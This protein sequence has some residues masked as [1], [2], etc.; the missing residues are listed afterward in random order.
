MDLKIKIKNKTAHISYLISL[1]Y[2]FII[3]LSIAFMNILI[4]GFCIL[5]ILFLFEDG[6]LKH[7][8]YEINNRQK[9]FIAVGFLIFVFYLL[10]I[11]KSNDKLK[12]LE[13]AGRI[14]SFV[15]F[16]F[17]YLFYKEEIQ[18]RIENIL[19]AFI[20][21]N[22]IAVL[23]CMINA[24]Y[25]YNT[26]SDAERSVFFYRSFS[27]FRHPGYFS[28]YIS[29]AFVFLYHIYIKSY[30]KKNIIPKLIIY[31]IATLFIV[32]IF[33]LSSRAGFLAFFIVLVLIIINIFLQLSKIRSKIFLLAM[34]VIFISSWIYNP[35]FE[36]TKNNVENIFNKDAKTI[37]K[38]PRL[39]L[40]KASIE[41]I[42]ENLI[43]GV[44]TTNVSTNLY[45]KHKIE[46]R[47]GLHSHNQF[48]EFFAEF[49]IF[50]F[51]TIILFFIIIFIEIFRRSSFLLLNFTVI[52]ITAFMFEVFLEI[53]SGGAY[54]V[55]FFFYL[56][57]IAYE[58]NKIYDRPIKKTSQ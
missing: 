40:W 42:S 17:F 58:K 52:I 14:S 43:T 30:L 2:A 41:V 57:M 32:S 4:A 3:P 33:L 47:K 15:I 6:N 28:I 38:F 35:R 31:L 44:G 54:F 10:G 24:I 29:T 9:L 26:D 39:I 55:P 1:L 25:L 12:A 21:G 53:V 13:I 45:K 37:N 18:S 27:F 49:G 5:L 22:L 8:F 36:R 56:F 48:L 20:L 46:K 34:L 7:K 23:I 19:K 50:A 11:I 51:L 16:P